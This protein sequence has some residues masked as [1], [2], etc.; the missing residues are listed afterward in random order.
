MLTIGD[1]EGALLKLIIPNNNVRR[2]YY[3]W[4]MKEY[5]NIAK[6]DVTLLNKVYAD[7]ALRGEWRPMLEEIARAYHDTTSVRQLMEGERN[8][9]GFMNAYL[10][11]NPYYLLAP[12]VELNHGYCDFFLMPDFL[13]YPM[14]RHSFILELK[15]LKV[16]ATPAESERQWQDAEEQIRRYAQGPRVR[17][18][19]GDTPLHLLIL[20][21][22]GYDMERM[23]EV[24]L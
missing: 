8:V 6:V 21:F 15:Y 10:S 2:Q 20:Q 3:D 18:L 19:I 16:D 1:V 22:R 17:Q 7:A 24:M 5:Q 12:E 11:L 23:G 4:L 9:Q 13:R 14:V